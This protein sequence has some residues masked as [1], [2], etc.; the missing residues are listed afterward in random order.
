MNPWEV[1]AGIIAIFTLAGSILYHLFK[2]TWWMATLTNALNTLVKSVD[3]IKIQMKQYEND[4]YSKMDAARDF[5]VRD[6]S[7]AAA[8]RRLDELK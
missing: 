4:H 1:V 8:H 7:I 6:A 3:D 2:T 5:A